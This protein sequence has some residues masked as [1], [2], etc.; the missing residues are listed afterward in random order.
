MTYMI[1]IY[2]VYLFV[3]VAVTIWVARN[4]RLNG[5][6]YVTDGKDENPVLIDAISHL[7]IVGFYLINF[8]L[9]SLVLKFGSNVS[10]P[11][12]AVELLSTKVGGVLLGLGCMHFVILM[13]FSGLRKNQ[14]SIFEPVDGPPRS[15][16]A[17][18]DHVA[19]RRDG[20]H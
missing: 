9:I 5:K 20:V 19:A 11:Q 17:L 12:S 15:T 18:A 13:V 2:A 8:G 3:C 1:G 10:D 7:L 6:I 16:A 14:R 4:L